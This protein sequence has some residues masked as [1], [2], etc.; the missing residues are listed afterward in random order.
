[1]AESGQMKMRKIRRRVSP[2]LLEAIRKPLTDSRKHGNQTSGPSDIVSPADGS[3]LAPFI[4]SIKINVA[5]DNK[6]SI[7]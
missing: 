5:E 7:A 2:E 3:N 6:N 4:R 1:M